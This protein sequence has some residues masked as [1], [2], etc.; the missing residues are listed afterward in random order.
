[1]QNNV[2]ELGAK[3]RNGFFL[4]SM[5][6]VTDGAF[7]AQRCAGCAMVQL[8]AYLAEPTAGPKEIGPH[9]SSFLPADP[10]AWTTFLARECQEAR[11][12]TGIAIAL[13]L[14]TLRLEWAMEAGRCFA[15]AGGDAL[16]LNV[17]GGYGR[18]LKRG[19]LRAMVEPEHQPELYR[20]VE[21]LAGLWRPSQ[22]A[23]PG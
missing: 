21:A 14:A 8:G 11:G 1:M 5:M 4:S 3:L 7:C 22:R 9:T 18:Y 20:W 23:Q 15:Q 16:E 2:R 17:H 12:G 6:G 10:D 13:N 19:K